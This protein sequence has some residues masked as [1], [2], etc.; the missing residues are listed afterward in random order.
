MVKMT[1]PVAAAE[2]PAK[3]ENGQEI[4][5]P[6]KEITSEREPSPPKSSKRKSPARGSAKK[7]SKEK[8]GKEQALDF[9]LDQ[10]KR[11]CGEGSIMFLGADH[12]VDVA[13]ISTGSLSL[14]V[15]LG[16]GGVPRGRIVEIYGPDPR[17]HRQCPE[18][19]WIGGVHRCR[20][21]SGP[22]LCPQA[23]SESRY[24]ACLAAGFGGAGPRDCRDAGELQCPLCDRYRQRS[25]SCTPG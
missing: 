22:D 18:G 5:V 2:L 25:G 23:G 17:D 20:A 15:A 13:T 7:D 19:G 4:A 14:D 8:K 21:C 12:K 6:E 16:V 3:Q 9:A 1:T 10:I 11:K 24:P